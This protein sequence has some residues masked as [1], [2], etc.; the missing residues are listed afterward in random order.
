MQEDLERREGSAKRAKTDSE[1]AEE[2]FRRQL[3]KLQE[4]GVKLRQKRE[5]ALKTAAKEAE[6][7]N[8]EMV[9][10]ESR[11]S[12]LDRTVR[13]RWKRRGNEDVTAE[14]L[15]RLFSRFGKVQDCIVPPDA[16]PKPGEK[17]KKLKTALL[18]FESIVSAHA[19]VHDALSKGNEDFRVFKDIAWA[20]GKEPDIS[21]ENTPDPQEKPASPAPTSRKPWA[22]P[23]ATTASK[24]K[25]PSFAS[26]SANRASSP[27]VAQNTDYESITLMRMRAAEKAKM[28]AE[29]RRQD[30][31]QVGDGDV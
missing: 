11:F 13:L 12:E 1:D 23:A 27:A 15:R 16:V 20:G 8:V 25:P 30:E 2:A 3:E 4:E 21:H 31:E 28:E 19:A 9:D 14:R 24:G 17:E 5:E 29:I 26:F 18:V 22:P 6:S 10:V 7:E